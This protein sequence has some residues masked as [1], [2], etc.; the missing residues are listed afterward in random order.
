MKKAKTKETAKNRVLATIK[1]HGNGWV[2]S[3][4][5]LLPDLQRWEIDQS[6]IALEK[7][8]VIS[9]ILPGLYYYPEYSKLLNKNIAPDIRKTAEAIARKYD[10]KIFP[11]GNTALNYLG[12]STQIPAKYIYISNGRSKKYKIGK[13]DLEFRHRVLT[14]TM[15]NN[16][17]AMLTVQ[18][19]RAIRQVHADNDFINK[20]SKKFS[21]KEWCKIEKASH[22]VT[23]W[24][25][26]VIRKAKEFSKNG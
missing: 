1:K 12:L 22:K 10:W 20:L 8:G 2:F 6:F 3:A 5:D 18:A 19:I 21:H 15:I 17:N 11:E 26:D 7:E 16:E 4:I 23:G 13:M 9:R 14:E 24:V 25:F